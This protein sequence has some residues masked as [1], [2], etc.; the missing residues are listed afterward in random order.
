MSEQM[1]VELVLQLYSASYQQQPSPKVERKVVQQTTPPTIIKPLT[2]IA[3]LGIP[4]PNPGTLDATGFILALRHAGMRKKD[5]GKLLRHPTLILQDEK[6]A[7]AAWVGYQW[8]NPHG[9]QL[10][11]A[12]FKAR[13]AIKPERAV[14]YKRGIAATIAGFVKGMPSL[15]DRYRNDLLAREQYSAELASTYEKA[16][17]EAKTEQDRLLNQGKMLV[18]RERLSV[19]RQDLIALAVA[20]AQEK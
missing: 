5:D 13:F 16:M 20:Q 15:A 3:P 11:H 6:I 18:E 17:D 19:I 1:A 8:G 10:D 2:K 12:R 7:I 14:E 9:L 4:I